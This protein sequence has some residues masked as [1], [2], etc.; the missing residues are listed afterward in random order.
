MA[1]KTFRGIVH[2]HSSY[3]HDGENDLDEL[4]SILGR[5]QLNFALLTEHVEDLS[6]VDFEHYVERCQSLSTDDLL[7]VPGLEYTF[8]DESKRIEILV[9]GREAYI[10]AVD[11]D[12]IWSHKKKH[13]LLAIL[14]HPRKLGK[15][16]KI[17]E[18]F[19][20]LI[21]V[22]NLRFDGGYF[23]PRD[24]WEL[25]EELRRKKEIYAVGGV[26]YHNLSDRI[27]LVVVLKE[28]EDLDSTPLLQTLKE[29]RFHTEYR[30]LCL[31]SDLQMVQWKRSVRLFGRLVRR[32]IYHTGR[33]VGHSTMGNILISTD[34]RRRVGRWVK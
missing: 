10:N 32:C 34:V 23:L 22:W 11:I 12:Q 29:G 26:D 17:I 7:L 4:V 15:T 5:Q 2:I 6:A 30:G 20:D 25:F 14:P 3:S 21:E 31:R 19:Y 24:N 28:L 1:N 8:E 27:D 9:F 13:D 18:P 33:I 16:V